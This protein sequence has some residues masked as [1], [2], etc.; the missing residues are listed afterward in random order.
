MSFTGYRWYVVRERILNG[1]L[2]YFT[3]QSNYQKKPGG[4]TVEV[5]GPYRDKFD[6]DRERELMEWS[7]AS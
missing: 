6:A 3:I 2:R 1:S 4:D 7:R 5:H